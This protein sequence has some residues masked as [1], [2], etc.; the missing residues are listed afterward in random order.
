[1]RPEDGVLSWSDPGICAG[2]AI[3]QAVAEKGIL[4]SSI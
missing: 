3:D 1:M 2:Q 4:G